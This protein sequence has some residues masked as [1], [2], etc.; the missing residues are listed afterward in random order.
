MGGVAGSGQA[1]RG[2]AG[3]GQA[4]GEADFGRAPPYN[5]AHFDDYVAGGSD[6]ADEATFR[7]APRAGE[8]A[9]DFTLPRFGDGAQI[10]LSELWRAK[11]LVME[12]GSFT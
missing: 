5:Y 3:S 10:R 2:V 6:V 7:E 9:P 11:P 4:E 12:F 1:E 8:R